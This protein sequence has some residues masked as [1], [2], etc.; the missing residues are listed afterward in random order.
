[1]LKEYKNVKQY[2]GEKKRK[3]FSDQ[4]FDL[5]LWMDNEKEIFGFQLCYDIYGN[6]HSLT[7]KKT[8]F[9]KHNK[10]DDGEKP[11]SMSRTPILVPDGIIPYKKIID[12][13]LDR[14]PVEKGLNRDLLLFVYDKILEYA[15]KGG[16]FL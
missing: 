13:F 16:A 3:W 7:W 12:E 14:F 5:I 8:G 1:M 6:E 4:F 2:P 15:D 10:V 11:F 9:Y